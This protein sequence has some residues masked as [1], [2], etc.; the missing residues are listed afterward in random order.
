MAKNK[1]GIQ[2]MK[3]LKTIDTVRE[4]ERERATD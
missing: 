3:K 2:R 4:R 1:G